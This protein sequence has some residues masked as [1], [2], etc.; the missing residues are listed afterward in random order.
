MTPTD[1]ALFRDGAASITLDQIV[2]ALGAQTS[3]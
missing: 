2:S 1:I 3:S